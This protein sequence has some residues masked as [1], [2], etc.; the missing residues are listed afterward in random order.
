MG[1]LSGATLCELVR[2]AYACVYVCVDG[3]DIHCLREGDHL[4]EY[5]VWGYYMRERESP[6]GFTIKSS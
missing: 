6:L 5:G 2:C 3:G 4:E 1:T